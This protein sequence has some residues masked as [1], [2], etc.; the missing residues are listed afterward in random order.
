ML[1]FSNGVCL[2]THAANQK[3][4]LI[5]RF[6]RSNGQNKCRMNDKCSRKQS[7]SASTFNF[8]LLLSF[9]IVQVALEKPC[10]WFVQ[11]KQ[12]D[13]IFKTQLQFSLTIHLKKNISWESF[14]LN[15]ISV[16]YCENG[17]HSVYLV[18]IFGA[19]ILV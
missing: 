13:I 5:L 11:I 2:Q 1:A 6:I 19:P 12:I 7:I 3:T 8:T 9:I 10:Q 15:I 14:F 18:W 4:V 17:T 16:T